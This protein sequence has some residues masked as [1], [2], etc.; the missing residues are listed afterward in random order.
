MV[1]KN[2]HPT[3]HKK[4]HAFFTGSGLFG[5]EFEKATEHNVG[6]GRIETRGILTSSDVPVGYTGFP[7]VHQLFCLTRTVVK[8]KTGEVR[9]E[10]VYG[11]TDL[12]KQQA[13]ASELLGFVREHWHI[14]NKSHH[15]RD[16][17]FDEDRSRVRCGNIPQLMAS[18]RNVCIS[19]MRAADCSNIAAACRK[20]AANPSEALRLLG[21]PRTE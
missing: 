13:S 15:V 5:A 11:M 20:F 3:L 9:Q 7:G 10:S 6:H 19:L 16:V 14:E 1:V 12:T 17:T 2:N 18:L 4:L 8:K 21:L